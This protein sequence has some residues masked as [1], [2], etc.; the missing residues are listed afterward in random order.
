MMFF[1]D[2]DI[3]VSF[4]D[5]IYFCDIISTK[6]FLFAVCIVCIRYRA[7]KLNLTLRSRTVVR[8]IHF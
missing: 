8:S 7:F 3:F 4:F 5:E 6:F 2:S 1:D